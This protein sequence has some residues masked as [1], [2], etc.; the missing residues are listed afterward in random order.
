MEAKILSIRFLSSVTSARVWR[1]EAEEAGIFDGDGG[2]VGKHGQQIPF[3]FRKD[4]GADAVIGINDPDH[5][6]LDLERHAK[7]G[8]QVIGHDTF[9]TAEARV[10]LG[11]GGQHGFASYR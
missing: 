11:I 2:L 9:M 1:T 4:A 10:L 7:D 3:G 5:I 6:A 8:P